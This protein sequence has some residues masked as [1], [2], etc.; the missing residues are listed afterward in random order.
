[1]QD[2]VIVLDEEQGVIR[3]RNQVAQSF[4]PYILPLI[5][6]CDRCLKGAGLSAMGE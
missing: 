2:D 3:D 5:N 4:P 1:M 6:Q